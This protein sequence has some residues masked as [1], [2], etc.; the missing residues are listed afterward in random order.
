M[1]SAAVASARPRSGP[2][3]ATKWERERW[4]FGSMAVAATLTI[5]WGFA[6]T[7]YLRPRYGTPALS[8]LLQLHGAVFT[9]WMVLYVIQ[10]ALIATKRVTVHRRLGTVGAMLAGAMVV[11]GI[12]VALAAARRPAINLPEGFPGP[13]IFLVI[14][15]GDM[16]AFAALVGLGLYN[17]RNR[18]INKR[19]MLLA[20]IAILNAGLGRLFFPGGVLAFLG[21]PPNPLTLVALTALFIVACLVYDRTARGRIHPAF[22]W[23]GLFILA[24]DLGRLALGGTAAWLTFA[25]WLTS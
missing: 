18:D 21:L 4:F 1:T 11:L 14:P 23:G 20:T 17:R 3:P 6:P 16:V 15:L 8:W 24:M 5:F 22:L 7:Y 19:M 9:A 25:R 2:P 12:T 13:L 10:T